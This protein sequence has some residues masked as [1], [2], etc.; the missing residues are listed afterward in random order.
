MLCYQA[1]HSRCVVHLVA[2]VHQLLHAGYA[3]ER[4]GNKY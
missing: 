3:D 1:A 4:G 2:D